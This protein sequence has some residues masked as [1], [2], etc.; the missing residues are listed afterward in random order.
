MTGFVDSPVCSPEPV[1]RQELD[2]STSWWSSLRKDLER[3]TAVRTDRVAVR[4]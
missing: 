2:L 4:Q 3:L 1:L